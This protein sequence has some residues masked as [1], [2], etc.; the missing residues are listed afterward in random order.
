M[1]WRKLF[2][3]IFLFSLVDGFISNWRYPAKLPFLY[4]DILILAMYIAFFITR[5]PGKRWFS[6]FRRQVGSGVWYLAMSLFFLGMLQIFNPEVPAALIGALGFKTTFF[7][8]PL[9]ILAYAYVDDLDCLER[10]MKTI[11]YLSI[12]ICLFG[13]FQFFQDKDF[14]VRVFGEGFKRAMVITSGSARA[15]FFLRVFGT[16]ASAGQFTSF[17]VINIMFILGLLFSAKNKF[18]KVIISGCLVL[19]YIT[20]LCTGTRAGLLLLFPTGFIF[21]MLCRWLWRTFFIALLL[22]V[23]LG[24]GFNY[25]GRAVF[26]RFETVRNIEMIRGRTIETTTKMFKNYLEEHPFGR[27]MGTATL[28]SRHLFSELPS[29][30]EFIENYPTKLLVELGIAGVI[31]Y[32]M[33]LI[34]LFI[35]WATHWLK[36]ADKR[37]RVLIAALTAYCWTM[38]VYALFGIID[39]PPI[40]MFLWAEIGMVA[41]LARLQSDDQYPVSA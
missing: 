6:E 41:K 21:V 36:M 25:L 14:M 28:A 11:V 5:E 39:A 34:S 30:I 32:Y 2:P 13:I 27:G 31:L 18:E 9:A 23:S 1:N 20:V 17:L 35:H 15:G 19:N 4:K 12:P 33:L 29:E 38:F 10:F 3:I 24:L 7:Y 8:W 26:A 22:A 40:G 16:F 37:A